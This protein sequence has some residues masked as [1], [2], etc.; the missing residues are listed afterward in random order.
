[1]PSCQDKFEEEYEVLALDYDKIDVKHE[2]GKYTF[3]V[4]CS[5][6]WTITL[7]KEVDWVTFD[8]T[9]GRGVTMVN[10]EFGKNEALKRSFN[11]TVSDG[12][13]TRVIPVVQVSPVTSWLL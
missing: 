6:D 8:K 12:V 2:G 13:E 1:M 9:S 4:Y 10:I 7:D 11:M 5:G 3:M